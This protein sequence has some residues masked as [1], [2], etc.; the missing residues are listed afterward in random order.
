LSI[1]Q[2]AIRQLF[3]QFI[4]SILSK[5]SVIWKTSIHCQ[6]FRYFSSSI[7]ESSTLA[8]R[9]HF[10]ITAWKKG[11]REKERQKKKR[12]SFSIQKLFGISRMHFATT[13]TRS[14]S[15][16]FSQFSKSRA[17]GSTTILQC[18][19]ST[20]FK[21]LPDSA[22]EV[23]PYL[24][25]ASRSWS[26]IGSKFGLDLNVHSLESVLPLTLPGGFVPYLYDYSF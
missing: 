16:R 19:S 3:C 15:R 12:L 26:R 9:T 22:L 8:T 20:K 13:T 6:I 5:L 25:L 11:K 21:R 1:Y 17:D 18:C 4:T 7:D 10:V 14:I 2:E 23:S 24:P